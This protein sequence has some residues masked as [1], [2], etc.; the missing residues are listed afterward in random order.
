VQRQ[1][2]RFRAGFLKSAGL[3]EKNSFERQPGGGP[4][5]PDAPASRSLDRLEHELAAGLFG[6]TAEWQRLG[7][8][9]AVRQAAGI[10][11]GNGRLVSAAKEQDENRGDEQEAGHNDDE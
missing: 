2:L 3:A 10:A 4:I 6:N 11:G 7:G 8:S 9:G 1:E 5:G